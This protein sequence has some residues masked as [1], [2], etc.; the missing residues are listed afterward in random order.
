MRGRCVT[1]SEFQ[2]RPSPEC[3]EHEI[4]DSALGAQFV[5]VVEQWLRLV[6]LAV[7]VEQLSNNEPASFAT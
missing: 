6:E 1:A 2:A 7:F 3:R 5:R 4:D